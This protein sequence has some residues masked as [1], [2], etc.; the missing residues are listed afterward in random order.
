[1]LFVAALYF[2]V[3]FRKFYEFIFPISAH[4]K[5]VTGFQPD[6]NAAQN[7]RFRVKWKQMCTMHYQPL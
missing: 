7:R 3:V 6:A 2:R 4:I 1:M 5:S